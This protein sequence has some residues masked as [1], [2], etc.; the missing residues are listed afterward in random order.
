M[1]FTS[2]IDSVASDMIASHAKNELED[3]I[4]PPGSKIVKIAGSK[5]SA[6]LLVTFRDIVANKNKIEAKI[7]SEFKSW[8]DPVIK[9]TSVKFINDIKCE[10][11][12]KW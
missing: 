10:I 3:Y 11:G 6:T 8:V 5:N 4:L 12:L 7:K 1:K 9:A 2:L